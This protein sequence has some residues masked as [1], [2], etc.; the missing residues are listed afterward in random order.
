[1]A[2]RLGVAV[3]LVLAGAGL[4][5]VG[6]SS[7]SAASP[8][9]S[10][11]PTPSRSGASDGSLRAVSCASASQCFAVGTEGTGIDPQ[12]L[13][14]SWNGSR[15]SIVKSL[16]VGISGSSLDSIS[17]TSAWCMAIGNYQNFVAGPQVLIEAWSGSTWSTIPTPNPVNAEDV[18]LASVSCLSAT[19]C[20]AVGSYESSTSGSVVTLVESWN[21]SNWSQVS[22]P[23][24][25]GDE[26]FLNGVSCA[27]ASACMAV[28]GAENVE[29]GAEQ[30]LTESWNGSTWSIVA[31]P[32]QGLGENNYLNGVS[33]RSATSCTAVGLYDSSGSKPLVESWNGTTWSIAA[34][35]GTGNLNSVSCATAKFCIAVG[36]AGVVRWNGSTWS[37]VLSNKHLSAVSC[38][39]ASTCMAAGNLKISTIVRHALVVSW[40]AG[41]WSTVPSPSRLTY[42]NVLAGV[43]CPSA[44]SCVAVGHY[45]DSKSVMQTLVESWNGSTWSIV[46]SPNEGTL[47]SSLDSISCTSASACMAVGSYTTA[48]SAQPLIESWNGKTWSILSSAAISGQSP[49]L[50]GVSC[51]SAKS[52]M[53][54]GVYGTVAGEDFTTFTEAWNGKTWSVVPSVNSSGQTYLNGV[55]CVSAKSCT[56]AGWYATTGGLGETLIESWNGSAWSVVTSPNE[57]EDTNTLVGI[58]C[59]S[60]SSCT[61]VG[62]AAGVGYGG[63]TQTRVESWNGSTWSIVPSADQ[64]TQSNYLAGISCRSASSCIAVGE[65]GTVSDHSVAKALIESWNGSTWSIL[66]SPSVSALDPQLFAVSCTTT[67]SCMATGEI[68]AGNQASLAERSG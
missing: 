39:S 14:E 35:P 68:G 5:A 61:A 46:A 49:Q 63:A 62:S 15:W 3:A 22:S 23:N 59:L 34:S 67:T 30:T 38:V 52:C 11:V 10:V 51:T 42:S 2:G 58:S 55:S 24:V 54:V 4:A 53:A 50:T 48:G 8:A 26:T 16:S 29:G 45:L 13:I 65:V 12:T 18:D 31:S 60:A 28:G 27:S 44:T 33:C 57:G 6:G 41:K 20:T 21:G 56:A 47:G 64:G 37:D 25:S 66:P 32:N 40:H 17:C 1:L 9:W 43:S 36:S 7:A 19:A